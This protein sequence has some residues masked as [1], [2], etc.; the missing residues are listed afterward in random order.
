MPNLPINE[1]HEEERRS[2]TSR[3]DRLR[4]TISEQT[5]KNTEARYSAICSMT[6]KEGIK[7]EIL[8]CFPDHNHKVIRDFFIAHPVCWTDIQRKIF[9]IRKYDKIWY[10]EDRELWNI[11][12][13]FMIRGRKN[14]IWEKIRRLLPDAITRNQNLLAFSGAQPSLLDEGW[15]MFSKISA[16][17]RKWHIRKLIT[18]GMIKNMNS[19]FDYIEAVKHMPTLFL[20]FLHYLKE[21][22]WK[23]IHI[24]HGRDFETIIKELDKM[25]D[26]WH[27]IQRENAFRIIQSFHAW[28]SI[29]QIEK[30]Y[31]LALERINLL[32]KKLEDIGIKLI[33]KICTIEH[34]GTT[35]YSANALHNWKPFRMEW[36]VKTVKSI[37]QKMWETEEYT[38]VDAIRDIIGISIIWS[39]ETPIDDKKNIITRFWTLMPDFWFL[40]KDKGGLWDNIFTVQE[41]LKNQKKNPVYISLK[42]WETTHPEFTNTSLS[43]YMQLGSEA[44]WTEVQ[45][46][47]EKAAKWKKED[48]KKYKPKGMINVLMRW[49]K[50]C[51]PRDCYELLNERV[52]AGRIK[53]LWFSDIN[54][55][56][57]Y[58]IENEEFIIPY[59]SKTGK[60]VLLTCKGKELAFTEKFPHLEKCIKWHSQY[61]KV[62]EYIRWLL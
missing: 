30:F 39:E 21:I 55:M 29:E 10:I 52:S 50:F 14:D 35:I 60:E 19:C 47:D 24:P 8:K 46:M 22:F 33:G 25:L 43:G 48:D 41:M 61:E 15:H 54:A 17:N 44:I 13:S 1:Y 5:I 6:T 51:T 36:R 31:E 27:G 23:T 18:T 49:P 38:N 4:G 7:W 57:L 62:R 32:P 53:E 11:Y 56:L 26:S 2:M 59:I 12:D 40:L 37:L 16:K 28:S 45:F 34:N 9:A 20:K 58:Y 3:I 42:V